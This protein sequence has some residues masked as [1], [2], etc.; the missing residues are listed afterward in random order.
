[1]QSSPKLTAFQS[2]AWSGSV[3]RVRFP[4]RH[5]IRRRMGFESTVPARI[6]IGLLHQAKKQS[7]AKK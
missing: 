6:P 7:W 1:M 4:I 2:K 3:R 5:P